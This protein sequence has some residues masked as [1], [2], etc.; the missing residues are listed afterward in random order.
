MLKNRRCLPRLT[1]QV[2]APR[3]R[4]VPNPLPTW[5]RFCRAV[6]KK[7]SRNRMF[8]GYHSKAGWEYHFRDIDKSTRTEGIIQ[9]IA[10]QAANVAPTRIRTQVHDAT[11]ELQSRVARRDAHPVRR[12]PGPTRRL[13]QRSQS[14]RKTLTCCQRGSRPAAKAKK[15]RYRWWRSQ[16]KCKQR[17]S[18]IR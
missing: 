1:L 18:G 14:S 5:K 9:G 2:A 16:P 4:T 12:P 6:A 11:G 8:F 3:F 7:T 15:S 10:R 17:E 13:Q